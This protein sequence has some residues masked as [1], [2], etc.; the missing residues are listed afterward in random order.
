MKL[1]AMLIAALTLSA[2]PLAAEEAASDQELG[3]PV[4]ALIPHD[5]SANAYDG[6]AQSFETLVSEKGMAL[7]FVRSVKWCPFC[8]IQAMDVDRRAG[9]FEDRGL[10]VV[11]VSYDPVADQQTF[12]QIRKIESMLL[13]DPESEIIDSFGIRNEQHKEGH[14]AF[15]V[16]HPVVFIVD[17]D[18]TIV[19]K[20]YETDYLTNDKSYR[21]RPAVDIIL[22]SVDAALSNG[23]L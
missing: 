8:Q 6:T 19:A 23:L 13:S 18:K 20:L 14:Y 11:F 16:P 3:P 17:P 2:A 1:T 21:D 5:L 22:E 4:G 7:F 12:V 15:G 10:R 9:E